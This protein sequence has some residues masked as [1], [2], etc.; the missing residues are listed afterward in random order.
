MQTHK[1]W[2]LTWL[3][4]LFKATVCLNNML[5]EYFD[6]EWLL[7][8]VKEWSKKGVINNLK[9]RTTLMNQSHIIQAYPLELCIVQRLMWRLKSSSLI[10]LKFCDPTFRQ[11]QLTRIHISWIISQIIDCWYSKIV[12]L[13]LLFWLLFICVLKFHIITTLL[14]YLI[15]RSYPLQRI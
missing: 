2:W 15:F 14:F 11:L 7:F 4:N 8:W 13:W 10:L 9:K 3:K 12:F 6:Q 5:C 1:L